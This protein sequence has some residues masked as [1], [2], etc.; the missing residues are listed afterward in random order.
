MNYVE[1][2][3]PSDE[4]CEQD[5]EYDCDRV[6][7]VNRL[8]QNQNPTTVRIRPLQEDANYLTKV[9][10]TTDSGV[11]K[12]LLSEKHYLKIK[13]R[14][15]NMTLRPTNVRFKPYSTD[16]TVPLLGCMEVKLANNKGK[17]IRSRVYVT[18]GQ[19]ESLLGKEDGIALGILKI[20]PDG[21]APD[22]DEER[23]RCITP[24]PLDDVIK[25]GIVSGDKDTGSNR[26]HYEAN[27]RGTQ[28][29]VPRHGKSQ[30]TAHS[31]TS[32]G[33]CQASYPAEKADS[34]A[35]T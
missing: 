32:Q 5:Y 16:T 25:Y 31:H 34:V 12:T 6:L 3:V 21:D 2:D 14:N 30:G 18:Q 19:S 4:D 9:P 27:R 23:V 24:E 26:Q 15:P 29:G 1:E 8:G 35:A 10:W 33:G 13:H 7:E 20:D 28:G 17:A 22:E 11:R